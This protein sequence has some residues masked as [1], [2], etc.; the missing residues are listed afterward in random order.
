LP[1]LPV[2]NIK[3]DAGRRLRSVSGLEGPGRRARRPS[4][5]GRRWNPPG[6][7][8]KETLADP[9]SRGVNDLAF[10]TPSHYIAAADANG[11]VYIWTVAAG[12]LN[13]A[14]TDPGSKGVRGVAYAPDGKSMSTADANGHL[15]IWAEPGYKLTA[16]LVNPAGK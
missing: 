13:A 5:S 10:T 2:S 1:G 6:Y 14:V 8:L 15:Y 4:R 9:D 16:T 11:H 7:K 12:S 3:R